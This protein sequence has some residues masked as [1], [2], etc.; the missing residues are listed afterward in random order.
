MTEA[1]PNIWRAIVSIFCLAAC[2]TEMTSVKAATPMKLPTIMKA[3]RSF[4]AA[5]HARRYD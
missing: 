4:V 2:P 3:V 1:S 5:Q